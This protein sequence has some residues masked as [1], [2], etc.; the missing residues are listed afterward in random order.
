[1]EL[2]EDVVEL[3]E[4]VTELPDCFVNIVC[5]KSGDLSSNVT[6][7]CGS[8][9]PAKELLKDGIDAKQ[10]W[11]KMHEDPFVIHTNS[12]LFAAHLLLRIALVPLKS[13]TEIGQIPVWQPK[14]SHTLRPYVLWVHVYQ[15]R[16]LPS[17]SNS[18]LGL[19]ASTA[20]SFPHV[21]VLVCGQK[22]NTKRHHSTRHPQ[23]FE[24]LAFVLSLPNKD[25]MPL[26][27]IQ[28]WDG[29][30]FK[31]RDIL[32]GATQCPIAN[33][34]FISQDRLARLLVAHNAKDWE[35]ANPLQKDTSFSTIPREHIAS[36]TWKSF[37]LGSLSGGSGSQGEIL[38]A[39]Q[40]FEVPERYA[41][42]GRRVGDAP[43]PVR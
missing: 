41:E 8:R 33:A 30:S 35:R 1:M 27:N 24:T 34:Q 22:K 36:P 7:V 38:I 39:F 18:I 15:C 29:A 31:R 20:P 40:L 4:D 6:N 17:Y 3:S 19:S 42:V 5:G 37:S 14:P 28:A 21:R 12:A 32:L 2:L 13:D 23:F 25:Y 26:I 43:K 11:M 10:K 9:I 16:N